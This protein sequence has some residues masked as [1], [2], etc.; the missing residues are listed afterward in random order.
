MK[1]VADATALQM[2]MT[3]QLRPYGEVRAASSFSFLDGAS[4]PEDLIQGAC[5]RGLPAM[6]LID[7]NGVYGAPRFYSAAKKNGVRALIGA[8]LVMGDFAREGLRLAAQSNGRNARVTV[9]VEN[10]TG[11]KTSAS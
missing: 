7:T 10:H 1:A 4:L 3:T 8:E 5:T 9:L 6:A 11:Y 2:N